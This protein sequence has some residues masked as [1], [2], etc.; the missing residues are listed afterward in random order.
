MITYGE[1]G[2]GTKKIEEQK[3]SEKRQFVKRFRMPFTVGV[4]T[5]LVVVLAYAVSFWG[6]AYP[7][8]EIAGT[9][10]GGLTK[11]EIAKII[12]AKESGFINLLIWS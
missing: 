3:V 6:R 2:K 11:D 8:V 1:M 9:N 5:V 7:K 12:I 10:V 4:L